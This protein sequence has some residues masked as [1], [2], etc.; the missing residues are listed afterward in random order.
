MPFSLLKGSRSWVWGGGTVLDLRPERGQKGHEPG[1]PGD[2]VHIPSLPSSQNGDET[3]T[4]PNN[5]FDTEMLQAMILASASG[6]LCQCE[7]WD[8]RLGVLGA[9][10]CHQA[11]G[12]AISLCGF[13]R[14]LTALRGPI[15]PGHKARLR[16][17][18]GSGSWD[19][20]P[21]RCIEER[22]GVVVQRP[23]VEGTARSGPSSAAYCLCEFGQWA[24]SH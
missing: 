9:P 1:Q 10:H 3:G 21:G 2:L 20:Q 18:E 16:I 14:S 13:S 17:A 15:L 5:Q 7:C 23:A 12:L 19:A 8:G 11:L 22:W 24:S 6:K 4:W